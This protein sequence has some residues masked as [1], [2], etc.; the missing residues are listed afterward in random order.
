MEH[1]LTVTETKMKDNHLLLIPIEQWPEKEWNALHDGMRM[2]ADSDALT[3]VYVLDS[4]DAFVQLRL[5]KKVW[6]QLKKAYEEG[7][8]VSASGPK[9]I[10]L[11]HFH[12]EMEY[13]LDNIPGNGN[14]GAAMVEAVEEAFD[15]SA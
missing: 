15:V 5:P 1:I 11:E 8:E 13:L 7:W 9:S 14:Y 10:K 12:S 6:P 4:E 3:F 2:L